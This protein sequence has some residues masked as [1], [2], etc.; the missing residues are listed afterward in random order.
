MLP[1]ST[2]GPR[3][4]NQTLQAIMYLF[5]VDVDRTWVIFLFVQTAIEYVKRQ[6]SRD[7][8]SSHRQN[9]MHTGFPAFDASPL[10]KALS[11]SESAGFILLNNE[12]DIVKV[13]LLAIV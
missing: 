4:L 6:K 1:E 13:A 10:V 8:Q 9:K 11:E 2:S 7:A 5:L 3:T 12:W